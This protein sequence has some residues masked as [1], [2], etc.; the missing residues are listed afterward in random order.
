MG[1]GAKR[2]RGA[3]C[4]RAVVR[5]WGREGHLGHVISLACYIMHDVY[6]SGWERGV[7]AGTPRE[8]ASQKNGKNAVTDRLRVITF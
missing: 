6:G 1:H 5:V 7:R 3:A 4:F 8:T 2:G